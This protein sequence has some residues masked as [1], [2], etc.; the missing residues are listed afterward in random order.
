MITR[1]CLIWSRR[2][3]SFF[4]EGGFCLIWFC[5]EW[6]EEPRA[7]SYFNNVKPI[8]GRFLIDMDAMSMFTL[9]YMTTLTIL[10]NYRLQKNITEYMFSPVSVYFVNTTVLIADRDLSLFTADGCY[11]GRKR[12][13]F[14]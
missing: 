2:L 10:P 14:L 7:V 1:V 8:P 3:T 12:P 6:G 11:R 5:F 13:C 4:L 9:Q